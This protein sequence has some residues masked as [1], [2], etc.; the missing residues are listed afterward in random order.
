VLTPQPGRALLH[1]GGLEH[2]VTP[3]QAGHRIHLIIWLEAEMHFGKFLQLPP[4][5]Q[6]LILSYLSASDLL[7]CARTCK[8]LH[9][10]AWNPALWTEL[11]QR[12]H[13]EL[14]DTNLPI[15]QKVRHRPEYI[16]VHI[17]D[18]YTTVNRARRALKLYLFPPSPPPFHTAAFL[19]GFS[20]ADAL[21]AGGISTLYRTRVEKNCA[22]DRYEDDQGLP[23]SLEHTPIPAAR[24][25]S[26]PVLTR[27]IRV[28]VLTRMRLPEREPAMNSYLLALAPQLLE[29]LL[30]PRPLSVMADNASRCQIQ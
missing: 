19:L 6:Q 20:C 8:A 1:E 11:K 13:E 3:L 30:F 16:P 23:P 9:K 7:A 5:L 10:I 24:M 26:A 27:M 2:N 29:T 15:P 14:P 4:E 25:A 28:P 12:L 21:R 17:Y 22:N 18:F